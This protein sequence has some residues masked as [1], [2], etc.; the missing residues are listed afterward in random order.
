VFFALLNIDNLRNICPNG[1]CFRHGRQDD[2]SPT[3][4]Q[5]IRLW[6]LILLRQ[7]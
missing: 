4:Q 2:T 6:L 1:W 7:G 5:S 3:H